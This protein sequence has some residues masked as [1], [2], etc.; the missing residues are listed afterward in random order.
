MYYPIR[1]YGRIFN[2]FHS[3]CDAGVGIGIGIWM[4]RYEV[5]IIMIH[6]RRASW[7]QALTEFFGSVS[8]R[9][10]DSPIYDKNRAIERS[11]LRYFLL[12][13][14][15]G[16]VPKCTHMCGISYVFRKMGTLK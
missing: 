13:N 10:M 3:H 14:S 4:I 12:R 6:P 11:N 9:N 8:M 5:D 1:F 16:K 15:D 7:A 2:L